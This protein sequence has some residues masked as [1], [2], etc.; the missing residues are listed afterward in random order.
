MHP[1]RSEEFLAWAEAKGIG[2]DDRYEEPRCLV[3][4]PPRDI[5]RFWVVPPD[6]AGWPRFIA[7]ML[8]GMGPWTT[9]YLWFRGGRWPGLTAPYDSDGG[10]REVILRGVGAPINLEGA[11]HFEKS[12]RDRV[13]GVIFAQLAFGWCSQD[14]LFVIPDHAGTILW[15]DHH[16]VIHANFADRRSVKQ[17]ARGMKASGYDLPTYLPDGTFKRQRW[18]KSAKD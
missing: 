18:M 9:G 1:I 11:A 7:A 6:P 8:D 14:D 10:I 3:H 5:G 17:F 2:P 16:R 12:E 13:V 15:V 4:K